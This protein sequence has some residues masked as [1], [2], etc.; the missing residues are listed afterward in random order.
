MKLCHPEYN[1]LSRNYWFGQMD[2][3]PLSLYRIC[4][5]ALLLKNALYLI[6]LSRRLYSDAGIVPRAPFWNGPYHSSYYL[7]LMDY[8]SADWM[9][10]LLFVAWGG[11]AL[12]LLVGYRTRLMSVLNFMLVISIHKRNVFVLTGADAVMSVLSFWI[13]FLPL[14]HYYILGAARARRLWNTISRRSSDPRVPQ[15]V[16]STYAFP[17]R[18]IQIQVALIYLFTV[19][20]KVLGGG[21]LEG[22][23]LHYAF[24]I[25]E[26]L[27]PAGEWVRSISPDWVLRVG[28]WS[29]VLIETLFTPLVFAPLVQPLLRAIG[30]TATFLLHLA[31]AVTMS[32]PDFSLVMWISFILFFEPQ[33][34]QWLERLARRAGGRFT[35]RS[36]DNRLIAP[37]TEINRSGHFRQFGLAALLVIVMTGTIW[38]S[39]YRALDT[40]DDS[41][42]SPMPKVFRTVLSELRLPNA[43]AMFRFDSMQRAGWLLIQGQFEDGTS[44]TLYSSVDPLSEQPTIYWGPEMHQRL[45]DTV[46]VNT[47]DSA[48][49]RAWSRY[50]CQLYKDNE[51]ENRPSNFHLATLEIHFRYRRSYRPGGALRPPEDDLL[52]SHKCQR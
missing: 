21:W 2:S 17:M 1:F 7:S 33:W 36:V 52:W 45:L 30:L 49:L 51:A 9:A 42:V 23:A 6:P 27:L 24:Q 40:F 14:D 29:T 10:A 18:M 46:V 19:Y 16:H 12:A 43:W 35:H 25:H 37:V 22:D 4:F 11:I 3:R 41:L 34:V 50:Y 31:I 15:A 5:G 8:L 26:L 44:K 32:I 13:I 20:T 47:R 48:V 39:L 28:T 38:E